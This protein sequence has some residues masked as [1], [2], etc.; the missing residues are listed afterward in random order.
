M[1]RK[2]GKGGFGQVFVGRRAVP[3]NAKDGPNANLVA[4]KFEHR[5]SKGCNYGPPYEWSVYRYGGGARAR[6]CVRVPCAWA[7]GAGRGRR[8][9][10]PP[11]STSLTHTLSSRSSPLSIHHSNQ[12][13]GGIHGI[14]RVHY[15]GRQGDYYVM[16]S[17]RERERAERGRACGVGRWRRERDGRARVPGTTTI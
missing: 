13:L 7:W 1:D 10:D 5:S 3:T 4:L 15:K 16:V 6:V 17:E 11:S 8:R 2:L 14:P 12:S 9:A